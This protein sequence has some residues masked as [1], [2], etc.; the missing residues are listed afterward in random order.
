[1]CVREREREREG[2]H[3]LDD[4]LLRQHVL[5]DH[6]GTLDNLQEDIESARNVRGPPIGVIIARRRHKIPSQTS[7]RHQIKT[8]RIVLLH[9]RGCLLVR[10]LHP[11]LLMR[12]RD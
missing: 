3:L 9:P 11:V 10:D 2:K 7:M 8:R 12:S 6:L 4:W 5:F 1:V